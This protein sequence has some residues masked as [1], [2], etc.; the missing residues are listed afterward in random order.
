LNLSDNNLDYEIKLDTVRSGFTPTHCWV[1]PK[2]GII[3]GNPP[4]VVMT[5]QKLLL[6]ESD[7]FGPLHEMHT[8]DLGKTWHGPIYHESFEMRHEEDDTLVG[9]CDFTPSWHAA[10]RKLLGIGHTV[11]YKN[12]RL[13]PGRTRETAYSVYDAE[14]KT[15]SPW[16]VVEMPDKNKFVSS[17]AGCAQRVDLENGDILI[18][19]YFSEST[20]DDAKR[21]F[22]VMRCSFDGNTLK[23]IEHGSEHI[24]NT[25]RG[26]LEPSLT[27]FRSTYYV[28]LRANE[29][30]YVSR[31]K[32]G[33]NF[34]E[35]RLWRWDD[36]S[37]LPTYNTQQHW[38]THSDGLFLVYTRI[39][40]NNGHVFRHR[41]PLFIAE[42]DPERMFIIRETERILVPERGARLGNFQVTNVTP[43][44][45]WITVSEWMQPIGC[46]KYGSDNSIY[47]A[48]ILWNKLNRYY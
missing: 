5:M 38:V 12:G 43:E 31:S 8:S 6:S 47:S 24:L 15:W 16:D 28:T 3:P 18:P 13:K 29:Y 10:S 41:A 4:T 19:I 34:E 48:R 39:A 45:T 7:V 11:R 22:T 36:G 23:Y 32:D 46:E 44:E 20:A 9:V 21:R 30:A 42:V 17:G 35:P 40:D 37:I 27:R 2:A 1:H 33:M 26:Y 25:G 14:T